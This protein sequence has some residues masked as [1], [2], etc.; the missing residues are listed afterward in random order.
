MVLNILAARSENVLVSVDATVEMTNFIHYRTLAL[1]GVDAGS[2]V[3][4]R[5]PDGR[6]PAYSSHH[7]RRITA[8]DFKSR[9][10]IT[11][12]HDADAL[13]LGDEEVSRI[14]VGTSQ[15]WP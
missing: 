3:L 2:G 10:G 1:S 11:V 4:H 12:L 5:H 13:L 6:C 15:A 9:V 7:L 8:S 14:Y